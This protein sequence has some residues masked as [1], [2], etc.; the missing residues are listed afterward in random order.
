MEARE[1]VMRLDL[2]RLS[3]EGWYKCMGFNMYIDVDV[4]LESLYMSF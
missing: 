1:V 3:F 4:D 2:L